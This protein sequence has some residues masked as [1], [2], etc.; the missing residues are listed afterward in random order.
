MKTGAAMEAPAESDGFLVEEYGRGSE[1]GT[2]SAGVRTGN[3]QAAGAGR[4]SGTRQAGTRPS[5]VQRAGAGR[6][7]GDRQ[8]RARAMARRKRRRRQRRMIIGGMLLL[9]LLL[10][11]GVLFGI[12]SYR[13]AKER[14][15]L[16]AEGV[17]SLES[18]SY[19]EAIK[20]FDEILTGSKGKVGTFEAEVLAYR[21]EAEYKQKDYPAALHTFELLVKED[22][23]KESYQKMLCY[24]QTELGNYEAALAYGYADAEV[25]N[26]MTLQNMEKQD[27]DTALE[28]VQKG[29]AACAPDSPVMKELTFNQAVIYEEKGD[30]TKAL[31]L[32]EAY[33]QTYGS[34]EE[35]E[36]EVAFLKTRQGSQQVQPEQ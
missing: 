32:F 10:I 13:A 16:L 34:D 2:R 5:G 36:R 4:P 35:A 33:L 11:G 20:T 27:Y 29:I 9:L 21:G 24:I 25:Y 15:T 28:N 30:F 1:I 6:P 12:F 22:G 7:S 19:E 26:R 31:E 3:R 8:A 18:G 23:E 14:Q 17:A